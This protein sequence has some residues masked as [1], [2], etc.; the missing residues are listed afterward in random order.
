MAIETR[1]FT[2]AQRMELRSHVELAGEAI[3]Q[4]WPMRTFIHHN[5]LHG[6]EDM[7]FPQAIKRGEHLLGGKGYLSNAIYRRF[8]EQ[9]R[10]GL[11]DVSCVLAPLASDRCVTFAGRELTHLELM[12][13]SMV[14]GLVDL[15]AKLQDSGAAGDTALDDLLAWLG[16]AVAGTR[17]RQPEPLVPWESLDLLSHETLSAWCDQTLG[18]CIVSDINEQMIKWCSVFLDEGEASWVMPNREQ[19]FYRAW[20]RLARY[21]AGLGLLGIQDAATKIDALGERPEEAVL[22]CLV[23]L[24]IPKSAWEAY[25]AL[26]LSALPGWAGYIKWRAEEQ[27]HPWQVRYPIDLVKYL[28][29]RLFYE[30]EFVE[31]HCRRAL[32][33]P[34]QYDAIRAI[35]DQAPYAHWLR[36]QLTARTIPPWAIREAEEWRRS[37]QA[38]TLDEWNQVGSRL[39]EQTSEW[40]GT[41]AMKR[42]AR[43]LLALAAALGTDPA[44]ISQTSVADAATVLNWLDGFPAGQQGQRWLEALEA[45]HRRDVVDEL[46]AVTKQLRDTDDRAAP[47]GSA[48]PLAQMVFCIDVR[49]EVFRRHLEQLGGYETF[50]VAGFFGIPVKYQA[51]GEEHPVTHA[52]VL[53]KPKNH[54]REIPRSYHGA[55]ASRHRLFAQ[56]S[57][58]AHTLLHDLKEN[59]ITPYVMVEALGWFFSLPFFGKTLCPL[60][61][62]RLT[63]SLK[64]LWV[65][66]LA[67]TLTIDKLTREEAEEMVA[68]EQRAVIRAALRQEFPAL[69]SA[70]TPALID[71]I[72]VGVMEDAEG[73]RG[74]DVAHILGISPV[75][76]AALYERFR[77]DFNLTPRGMSS[78]LQRI[79]QHGFSVSEQAYGVEA[80]LR[81]MGFTS[82]FSRLVVICSHGSTSDNNPYESALDCGACGGNSGLPNAR[83][84]ASMA[85]NA[86]VRKVLETR[87]IRIPGDTHFLAGLHDTTRNDVRIVDMEDIPAT[88]RKDLV[89]LLEDLREA[90]A[91]AAQERGLALGGPVA[92][93]SRK[94]PH[95][96][97]ARR[98]VDWA[99]V[100]PE[101]GLS[102][103]NLLIVGRRELTRPLN[104]QGRAFLHSYDHR[105]DSSGKLLEAIMTA[106]LIVAQWI[107]M[108]HYFST[109][110]NEVYGSGSKVYHNIVGRVG[111]MSG[112]NSDLR[113]G[114][115]AQTVLDGSMPYHEPMRLLTIIEAPRTR[116]ESVIATHPGL[117]RLF[118][119]E[120]VLL[121]VCEASEGAFYHYDIMRGWQPVSGLP[122]QSSAAAP[123][124]VRESAPFLHQKDGETVGSVQEATA[125]EQKRMNP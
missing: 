5:P 55:A 41:E 40:R 69:G 52:P 95:T 97:A 54:I 7:P 62:Q 34:G 112:A 44:L 13:V 22:S 119:N 113:L 53:L 14:H 38:A 60:A 17:I 104:L 43:R 47:A 1:A 79:T 32:N 50:G 121:V 110:D 46:R 105:Q 19:T 31:Y 16:T 42:D 124:F 114:L 39:Y 96:K 6:M 82:G 58:V 81:L 28:A 106:P 101:W 51:F 74:G 56:L 30:R 89:R 85:N 103:N 64:S 111:V 35:L 24:G 70:I 3:A 61:Y 108:E 91:Q 57:H 98:S 120:W 29:V 117:E 80:A 71:A 63:S 100:R 88:H 4:Y 25:F 123:R 102:R 2:E 15:P 37:H 73:Q 10:I 84:F 8:F 20:K 93:W 45:K 49:S 27:H 125:F 65:P 109:V 118:H 77:R 107:N 75:E 23:D 67:T 87:G 18:T 11:N 83:A 90:G 99:Q 92:T 48:R 66:P 26:H 59:V 78:R 94:D 115:P 9:G 76:V 33:R 86:A 68:V 116:V 122:E 12:R 36:R 72:R 21:D